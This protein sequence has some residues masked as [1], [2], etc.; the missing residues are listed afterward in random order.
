MH[1]ARLLLAFVALAGLASCDS[2][3]GDTPSAAFVPPPAGK[4]H[5]I[6]EVGDP[7][8]ALK[9]AS[10]SSVSVSGAVVVAV[11]TFDETHNGKGAG[12]IYVADLGS[13]EPYSGIS[14]FN[15]SWVPGNLR[16][17]AG[18]A[19]DLAGT[20]QENSSVPILFPPDTYLVQIANPIGTFRYEAMVPEPVEIEIEELSKFDTGRK[21]MNMIVTVHDVT[22]EDDLTAPPASGRQSGGLLP[23]IN[24]GK[25]PNGS[26]CPA[27]PT[28]PS[29]VNELM[30]L[31]P[32]Q[33]KKGT[34]LKSLTGVVTFFCNI[35]IAPRT[36]A[37]IVVDK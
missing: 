17:G 5:R 4:G 33:I 29:L 15:P 12:T 23:D 28:P 20:Y 9:A 10:G 13:A 35:H 21:W 24:S 34:K 36:E 26:V 30:D 14:L 2:Q 22:V 25:S 3:F 31:V 16:V 32:I 1:H 6:Y 11:D 7:A 27:F 19:L 8:N 37:D 18:D